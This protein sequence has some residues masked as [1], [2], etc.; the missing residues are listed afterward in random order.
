MN[1]QKKRVITAFEI[2]L[3]VSLSFSFSYILNQAYGETSING[4]LRNT[5]NQQK[6]W[7][8]YTLP[9]YK[10]LVN[11][12]WNEKTMVSALEQGAYTCLKTKTGA[13]CQEFPV[14]NTQ[15]LEECNSAC[16]TECLPIPR[17]QVSQ[18]KIGTCYDTIE[19]TCQAGSPKA[20]C[21]NFQGQW[22]NDPYE[23]VL[24]CKEGCCV[25]GDQTRFVS[26]RQCER[27]SEQLGLAKDFRPEINTELSCLVLAKAQEEG[28]CVFES[29]IPGEKNDCKFTTKSQ[30]LQSR[31]G[32]YLGV[33]CSATELNTRCEKQSTSQ[34]VEGRDQI[35]WFDSCGNRENVYSANKDQSY[36]SGK[37]L[38]FNE[39]CSLGTSTNPF[40]NQGSCGNCNYLSGST[41]GEKSTA[42]KLSDDTQD[43]VCR[44]LR[45]VDS[46]G[47]TRKNGESWCEY[48]GAIGVDESVKGLRSVDTPGSRHFRLTCLDGEV[49]E[50]ACADYRN[51]ICV[52]QQSPA[53]SGS[54]SSAACRIN[55]WQQC[56]EYNTDVQGK[57]TA[58]KQA[59]ERRDNVCE[60]NPDCFIKEVNVDDNF[61][62]NLCAPKYPPG[63]DLKGNGESAESI[64]SLASQK[65]TV[66]YV[67][68]ISGWKCVAN[69]ECETAKFTQQLNDLCISLGD[70]G[71]SVNYN[72]EL[73][74]SYRVK[75]APKLGENY[76]SGI[77]KYSEPV[78]GQY[79][80]SSDVEEFF[81]SLGFPEGLGEADK[82]IDVTAKFNQV[83]MVAGMAGI[84]LAW[85]AGA[86]YLPAFLT[87]YTVSAPVVASGAGGYIGGT[88]GG[89]T[90]AQAGAAV[91]LAAAQGLTATSAPGLSAAGGA[92]AGAAIGFAATALLIKFLG[93][94]AG[95]D[96][97]VAY[98]L[99]AAGAVAGAMIGY[100]LAIGAKACAAGGVGCIIGAIV[101][102]IVL[103]LKLLGIG[104]TKKVIVEFSC[105]AWQ[106]PYG[107]ASC[108]ECGK[109]LLPCSRYSCSSLGQTCEFI[110][111]GTGSEECVNINPN[112]VTA[113]R[114]KP[115][116]SALSENYEYTEENENGFRIK[117]TGS[118]E[119]LPGYSQLQ[120]GV[121]LNEPAQCRFDTLHTD[122]FED[123]EFDFGG[124]SLFLWNH[125]QILEV[126]NLESLG[127]P[128][129]DPTRRA[130]YALYLR[131][132]DASGNANI[133]EKV[134]NFCV[135][136]G[137][138]LTAPLIT[139]RTPELEWVKYNETVLEAGIFTNEP[140]ECKWSKQDKSYENMEND[141]E[142]QNDIE[143][144]ELQGW[145]C[146]SS[147]P[148]EEN[149]NEYGFYIRCKDQPWLIE[150]T[151]AG[152]SGIRIDEGTDENGN[153]IQSVI[154][155]NEKR[156]RNV[157]SQGYKFVVKRSQSNLIIDSVAPDKNAK[158]EFGTLPASV[159]LIV[160]TS[161]G[162]N[163]NAE[164][165]Y[166]IG[167]N[168]I[169][170]FE[171]FR[172]EHKQIF[173]S[174]GSGDKNID[175][176]CE[177]GAGN[178][179][180]ETAMFS[181]IHDINPPII[182]RIYNSRGS[183]VIITDEP[184]ECIYTVGEN[185]R[186][187][188][189]CE[190]GFDSGDS[191]IKSMNGVDIVHTTSFD[192]SG[193][194]YIKCKD[195]FNNIPGACST[196]VRP[197]G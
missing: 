111:E 81:G 134:V 44:D 142:C 29:Q 5:E 118:E 196:I 46:D 110:N 98:G 87:A 2:V 120:F 24:Q 71:A 145:K 36:N 82:P 8:D 72:G 150:D 7:I 158:L 165:S 163:G 12:I 124:R 152:N 51:E 132:K 1:I 56:L 83:A 180:T 151:G 123:M 154:E 59:E 35:F 166:I 91:D 153:A 19:G 191:R 187:A 18:C 194:Y 90:A 73:S 63:F 23:N 129:Y 32:F 89:L 50:E 147:F 86:G 48:Q 195:E 96:P 174:F 140:A 26:E 74:E 41:C 100:N 112:D 13:I 133:Q 60:K 104:K 131:C 9:I 22:F 122:S 95:L 137:K 171:T 108:S 160:K 27:Q 126:P 34:C 190:F 178:T 54:F 179:A 127:L 149:K 175:I 138:D 144:R 176:I 114:I 21:E 130:E 69:C 58:R 172:K 173:Q 47:D 115:L 40:A 192:A 42:E 88:I 197:G 64:C 77:R 164:C 76:L 106:P 3:L 70:C 101:I 28:A 121:E 189:Q 162:I 84:G 30:C 117:G 107:G 125:T 99:M 109:D 38:S 184:A 25:L 116:Q 177:D 161:G 156:E 183:L 159:E 55:R 17:S 52:E 182:T 169:S 136:P 167:S 94:G 31:G 66:F 78:E 103:V 143:D 53:E 188:N 113:P 4:N 67:K 85:A 157:N 43:F 10:I 14:S 128:G 33:L 65:C 97:V 102:I 45:C 79:A 155:L 20:V 146:D 62:F 15:D 57:G 148:L 16:E 185:K 93:I 119:C 139:S 135:R 105:Q 141:L 68:K 186:K 170:F 6:S 39:S 37:I 181:V 92:L 80:E 11:I 49:R 168:K 193:T 61:K 75:K